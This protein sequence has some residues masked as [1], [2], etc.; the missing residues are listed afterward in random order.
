MS[1]ATIFAWL[2]ALPSLLDG[3]TRGAPI[4]RHDVNTL[5]IANASIETDSPKFWAAVLDVWSAYESGNG[6]AHIAGGCPGVPVGT[7]CRRDQGARYCSPWMI[8][9]ARVPSSATLLDEARIAI[10]VLQRVRERVSRFFL[11]GSMRASVVT[12]WAVVDLR[13]GRDSSRARNAICKRG[14]RMINVRTSGGIGER[15][16]KFYGVARR[17][18]THHWEPSGA[19]GGGLTGRIV[20]KRDG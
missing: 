20:S 2:L 1:A 12:V 7:P 4:R 14:A 13:V 17:E 19:N 15:G 6:D 16:E 8:A 5:A 10:A 18:P 9:C 11:S 3:Y